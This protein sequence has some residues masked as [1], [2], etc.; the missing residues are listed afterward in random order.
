[1]AASADLFGIDD[2][3][4]I[5]IFFLQ[6]IGTRWFLLAADGCVCFL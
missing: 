2:G 5:A 6:R 1:M 3:T 4:I